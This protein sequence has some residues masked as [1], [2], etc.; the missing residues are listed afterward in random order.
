MTNKFESMLKSVAL[1][2][3]VLA[4]G[5]AF[6]QDRDQNRA[7]SKDV[8]RYSQR[9]TAIAPARIVTTSYPVTSKSVQLIGR[10]FTQPEVVEVKMTGIPPQVISKGVARMQYERRSK[11]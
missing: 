6:G 9:K 3:A 11:D 1:A 8:N 5:S 7:L 4:C 10:R 2:L